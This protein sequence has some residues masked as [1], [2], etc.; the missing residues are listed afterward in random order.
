MSFD[1]QN[2]LDR[3][4]IAYRDHGP[5]VGKD[6]VVTHCPMCSHADTGMHMSISTEGK[7][8]RCWRDHSHCGRSPVKLVQA[9]L[10]T[11]W[12]TAAAL[13]GFA[14][15]QPVQVHTRQSFLDTVKRLMAPQ[16]EEPAM[17]TIPDSARSLTLTLPIARPYR[18]YLRDRGFDDMR[19]LD[20]YDIMFEAR[21]R[22]W[23]GRILFP[24]KHE[25]QVVAMTGR[26]I[27]DQAEPRYLAEGP[28]DRYLIWADR[29]PKHALTLVL[30]EG[31][32]DA[33]KV[34]VLG[35]AKG[36]Y[37]TCCMTSD[38]SQHQRALLHTLMPR[39]ARTLV[40]F[41]K[42]NESGAMRLASHF[43]GRMHIATLPAYADDP[44]ELTGV[45][46]HIWKG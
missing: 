43:P 7:G 15:E 45:D 40:L 11:D 12:N 13:C 22:R 17:V 21:N 37:A 4:H 34:N 41:D 1:W 3:H 10:N 31:P 38:F 2:F 20:A 30:T 42:G 9:L 33:L 25:G 27:S 39:F 35:N 8:W 46:W 19:V 23:H 14:G 29:F 6:H 28:V 5:N 16:Q 24:V 18:L 44:A 32:F 26:G 36:I